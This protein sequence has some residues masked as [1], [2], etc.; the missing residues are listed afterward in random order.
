MIAPEPYRRGRIVGFVW[1]KE[2]D[3]VLVR[4]YETKGA[5]AC[6]A[7][8]P[9]RS[10]PSIYQRAVKLGVKTHRLWTEAE[11]HMIRSEWGF[12]SVVMIARSIA[13]TTKATYKRATEDLYLGNGVPDGNEFLTNAASR[14][15]FDVATLRRVL[16][17]AGVK[18]ELVRTR[19]KVKTNKRFSVDPSAVDAAVAKW[20]ASEAVEP[21]AKAR[22]IAG[23]TL[24]RWLLD[25]RV[26]RTL[27]AEGQV[28]RPHWRVPTVTIDKV[29]ADRRTARKKLESITTA[30][31]RVGLHWHTVRVRLAAFGISQKT[32]PWMLNPA[33][34]DRALAAHEEMRDRD[35][36][37]R[38]AARKARNQLRMSV[39]RA[40][41]KTPEPAAMDG[42]A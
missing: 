21:A 24:K 4:L 13:R 28:A 11:D 6:L 23:E 40:K 42:A 26:E 39:V 35:A 25:A 8:L 15:G 9:H 5:K 16:S 38:Y 7:A 22:G 10:L 37:A 17:F 30:A 34:V 41:A 31:K 12:R 14:T 29:V 19:L 2:D 36:V 33:D 1:S 20:L 27:V 18:P 3:D 32:R